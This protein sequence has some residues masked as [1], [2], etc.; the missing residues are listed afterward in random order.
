M[1]QRLVVDRIEDGARVVLEPMGSLEPV[2][3]PLAWLPEG[4]SEGDVLKV[5]RDSDGSVRFLQDEEARGARLR[6]MEA[7]RARLRRGPEGD[8]SL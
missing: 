8:L 7:R 2:V 6:E 3:L 4:V 1:T 5:E